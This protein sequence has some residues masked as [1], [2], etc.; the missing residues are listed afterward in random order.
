MRISKS[1]LSGAALSVPR[2]GSPSTGSA[3]R[4]ST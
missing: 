2:P 1:S 3:W 4:L